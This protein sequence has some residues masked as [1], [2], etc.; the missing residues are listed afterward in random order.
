MLQGHPLPCSSGMCWIS[1]AFLSLS[2]SQSCFLIFIFPSLTFTLFLKNDHHFDLSSDDFSKRLSERGIVGRK[3][4]PGACH[5]VGNHNKVGKSWAP[6]ESA[7]SSSCLSHLKQVIPP[8][9]GSALSSIQWEYFEYLHQKV[10]RRTKWK[11]SCK[12]SR[13]VPGT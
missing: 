1:S 7:S 10:V 4:V 9:E 13:P 12:M 11:N 5:M 3:L 8:L 2:T 6:L